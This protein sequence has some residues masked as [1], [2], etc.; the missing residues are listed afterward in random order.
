MGQA[1]MSQMKMS[2]PLRMRSDLHITRKVW[3][4]STG[5]IGLA[6]YKKAGVTPEFTASV[7]LTLAVAAFLFELLRLRNEKI[8]QLALILMNQ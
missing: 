1:F 6:I 5:L 2:S 3:H 7:L 4:I 8:N